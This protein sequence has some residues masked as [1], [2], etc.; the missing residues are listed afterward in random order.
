M[1]AALL[2]TVL[3]DL[4]RRGA[5]R[6]EAFPKRGEGLDPGDLWNGPEALLRRAGFTVARDDPVRPVLAMDL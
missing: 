4:P 5:R 3:A 2:A 1:A 6:M